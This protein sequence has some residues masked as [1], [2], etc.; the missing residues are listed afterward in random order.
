MRKI[1]RELEAKQREFLQANMDALEKV[2]QNLKVTLKWL[3]SKIKF[4]VER[5]YE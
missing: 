5:L 3:H 4:S 1:P 2:D